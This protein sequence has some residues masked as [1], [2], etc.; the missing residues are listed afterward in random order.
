MPDSIRLV[1]IGG[2]KASS[3][4]LM[5]WN[6]QVG[7]QVRLLNTYGPTE[8]TVVATMCD[9]T[10]TVPRDI[11][12][13]I[14]IGQPMPNVQTY[15]LD[16]SLQPVPIGVSGELY[17]GGNGLAR[18]YLNRPEL[19]AEKFIPDPFRGS[20]GRDCIRQAIWPVTFQMAILSLWVVSTFR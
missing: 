13:Q 8:A 3:E 1:I 2:E 16:T 12:E 5:R 10:H 17:I 20:Q 7:T 9:L 15:I 14:P 6:K 18:E 11:S 4:R 19:T